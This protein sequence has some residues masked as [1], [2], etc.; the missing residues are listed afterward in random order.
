MGRE[1]FK[2]C[3]PFRESV[4]ELDKVYAS[5]VGNSL[6][7]STG[8]FTGA[9]ADAKDSLG[10]PWP[11]AITLPALTLLQLALVDALA[12]VGVHPDAVVGHSAGETAVLS[13]SG[14]ASKAA[15]LEL[16]IARGRALALVEDAK[17]TMAAVNSS[18]KEAKKIIDEVNAELGKGVL[19][20]GC[21]NTPG[22]VTL[23]GAETHIDLAVAKASAAGI[24][25]RKLKT[26]VP[27]HSELMELCH[28][29]FDNLV[30]KLFSH[31]EIG[32]P[33]V[34]V[35]STVTGGLYERKFEPS[36]YWSGTLGPVRFE[37][38]IQA[39]LTKT[40]NATFVEIGPHPVLTAYLQSMSQAEGRENTPITCPLRRPRA[41]EPGIETFEFVSALGKV[42]TAG[43]NG[44]DFGVLY[45]SAESYT[46]PLPQYPFAL[47][48]VPWAIATPEF[49][50][51]RQQRNGPLNYPQL[52][53]NTRTHPGLADHVIKGE[54]VVPAAGFIEMVR[55]W[56]PLHR[57]KRYYSLTYQQAL[58]F[59]ASEVYNVQFYDL[60]SLSSERPTPV[61]VKL[62]G[63]KW[64]VRSAGSTDYAKTWP[65]DVR[66]QI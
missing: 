60:L 30:A 59:G 10:D 26:R 13:A 17:G 8:L 47:K 58:E 24:F 14:A 44:V 56:C 2:A 20:I 63:T 64:S 40:K 33:K 32:A 11:I 66:F 39:L 5:I 21:Y 6:I 4:L 16:A 35:Y 43:H 15:A 1:L 45:G 51:Q 28:E 18:P 42:V 41:P 52:Q 48:A 54:P 53:I 25:A 7:E 46:G 36:Y 65:I 61:Q 57:V 62:E 29:E 22:A 50:R 49:V 38:A 9:A 55:C 34:T 3:A 12:A 19:A 23:S 27:V 31:H 37:K